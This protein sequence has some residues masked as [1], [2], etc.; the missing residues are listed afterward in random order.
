LCPYLST[1]QVH[2]KKLGRSM[3]AVERNRLPESAAAAEAESHW[4]AA[5]EVTQHAEM[6][7]LTETVRGA[8][9]ESSQPEFD[10][11]VAF[12]TR[13]VQQVR[14][15][16][17][18]AKHT[19]QETA[20]AHRRVADEN[21][22]AAEEVR[23]LE[24]QLFRAKLS[25]GDELPLQLQW[26]RSAGHLTEKL[27]A[28]ALPAEAVRVLIAHM[29]VEKIAADRA[30]DAVG[31]ARQSLRQF[32]Y[33]F[34]LLKFGLQTYAELNLFLVLKCVEQCAEVS[35]SRSSP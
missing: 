21:A 27:Q 25:K 4:P 22:V 8:V 29:Y 1:Q 33:D 6:D 30:D 13:E 16:L 2:Q 9:P 24:T 5:E 14:E 20:H 10:R 19:I 34:F 12:H 18:E 31:D 28:P 3:S 23:R 35:A 11:L 17:A 15:R 32:V 7:A 26:V